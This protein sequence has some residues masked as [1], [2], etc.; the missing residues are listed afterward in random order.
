MKVVQKMVKLSCRRLRPS[1][2]LARHVEGETTLYVPRASLTESVPPTFPVFFN[3]AA[4]PSRDVAVCLASAEESMSFCDAMSGVGSRGVRVAR[5]AKHR[6]EVTLVDLNRAAMGL[7]RR[8]ARANGVLGKCEFVVG[9]ASS[10]LH[11]RYG[12]DMKFDWVDLDPFGSPV[13]QVPAVLSAVEDGGVAAFTAT[14]TAV[15]CG[16]YPKVAVRRYGGKPLNN[17]FHHETGLR[18]L[19]G[20]IVRQGAAQDLGVE[21]V[22]AHATRHYMRLA[23]R[24]RVGASRADESLRSTGFVWTCRV[25]GSMAAGK[26]PGRSCQECGEKV[27]YAGPLWLGRMAEEELVKAATKEARLRGLSEAEKILGGLQG[28]DSFPPWS[29]DLDELSSKMRVATIS[30][31]SLEKGLKDRGFRVSG[32]PFEERGVKTDAPSRQVVEAAR[33]VA[34]GNRHQLRKPAA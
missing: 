19:A 17:S 22:V 32:Q 18:L 25:C 8:S 16:V 4:K 7:A 27:D 10:F 28:V 20:A 12:K 1:L 5:E 14:D 34:P 15:L 9:E 3:K 6:P 11:S 30:R 24:V 21:P 13:R 23:V 33:E 26:E 2:E 29:F 31:D